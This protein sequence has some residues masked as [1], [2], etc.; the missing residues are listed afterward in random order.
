[1]KN[2]TFSFSLTIFGNSELFQNDEIFSSDP[3]HRLLHLSAVPLSG[4]VSRADLHVSQ[5]KGR[6]DVPVCAGEI[7]LTTLKLSD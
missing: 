6:A 4:R 7:M 3:L 1:M 2:P 5:G